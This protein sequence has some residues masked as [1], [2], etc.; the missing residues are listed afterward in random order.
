LR[1]CENLVQ[2]LICPRA[3]RLNLYL[4]KSY[5]SIYL[6]VNLVSN[7]LLRSLWVYRYQF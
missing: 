2:C 3:M 7:Y 4:S 5:T 6:N 1:P